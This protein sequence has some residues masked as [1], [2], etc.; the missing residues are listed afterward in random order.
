MD[1]QINA[2]SKRK[3][4][5]RLRWLGREV[6]HI[7]LTFITG[8][9]IATAYHQLVTSKS[10][11]SSLERVCIVYGRDE[12]ECKSGIDDILDE[13]DGVVDN[14]LNVKGE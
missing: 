9:A 10:I 11:R 12:Q 8:V 4:H 2:W 7:L 5:P 14:N 1:K 6:F 3:A 13:S